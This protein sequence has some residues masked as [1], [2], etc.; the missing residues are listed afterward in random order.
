MMDKPQPSVLDT[1][2]SA[3]T[4]YFMP[5]SWT[6]REGV[7][8]AWGPRRKTTAGAWQVSAVLIAV[9]AVASSALNVH[10]VDSLAKAENLLLQVHLQVPGGTLVNGYVTAIEGSVDAEL[11]S[12]AVQPSH[13]VVRLFANR[14]LKVVA[15]VRP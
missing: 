6:V 14:H 10:T 5:L 8:R 12:Q 11:T 7:P 1:A 13:S 9:Y 2:L 4:R 15:F 3:A